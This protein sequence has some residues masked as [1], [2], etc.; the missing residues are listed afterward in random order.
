[1]GFFT[2]VAEEAATWTALVTG[3]KIPTLHVRSLQGWGHPYRLKEL[4]LEP[5]SFSGGLLPTRRY[6]ATTVAATK[7]G[8]QSSDPPSSLAS[9][10]ACSRWKHCSRKKSSVCLAP[11]LVLRL[12]ADQC[13][14]G[15]SPSLAV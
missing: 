10:T 8:R 5:P 9:S 13:R 2:D 15:G 1:M 14:S 11:S 12:L 7:S 6:L 4:F 3:I